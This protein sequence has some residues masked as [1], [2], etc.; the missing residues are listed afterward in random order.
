MLKIKTNNYVNSI[1]ETDQATGMISI[2][3]AINGTELT[4]ERFGAVNLFCN[5]LDAI[6]FFSEALEIE[7]TMMRSSAYKSL[8]EV[9]S[10]YSFVD[11]GPYSQDERD[12]KVERVKRIIK[13]YGAFCLFTELYHS[14][15]KET[16]V[17]FETDFIVLDLEEIFQSNHYSYCLVRDLGKELGLIEDIRDIHNSLSVDINIAFLKLFGESSLNDYF[18]NRLNWGDHKYYMQSRKLSSGCSNYFAQ[19]ENCIQLDS[20]RTSQMQGNAFF[21]HQNLTLLA[22]SLFQILWPELLSNEE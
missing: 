22:V 14:P 5:T 3:N 18:F 16:D 10:T 20:P 1:T 21:M 19:R 12:E 7:N 15:P 4:P 8:H 9:Y 17:T 13:K 2:L 11:V 6:Q